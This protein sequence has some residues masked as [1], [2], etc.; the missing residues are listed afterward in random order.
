M[1]LGITQIFAVILN[2][3]QTSQVSKTCEV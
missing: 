1:G 2:L 3:D